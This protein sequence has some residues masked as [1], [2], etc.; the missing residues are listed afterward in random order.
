MCACM[1]SALAGELA[2]CRR[3]QQPPLLCC[4][5]PI[6]DCLA[7]PPP[8]TQ[9]SLPPHIHTPHGR[10]LTTSAGRPL[11]LPRRPRRHHPGRGPPAQPRLRHRAPLVRHVLLLHQPGHRAA[12]AVERARQGHLRE[13]GLRPSQAPRREGAAAAAAGRGGG[14]GLLRWRG[15]CGG[16]ASRRHEPRIAL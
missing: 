3:L 1:S 12:G 10:P 9:P 13:Q 4:V 7:S 6:H 16:V 15:C 14:G 5:P 8:L 2:G 11:H